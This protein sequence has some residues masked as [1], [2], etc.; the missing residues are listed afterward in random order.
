MMMTRSLP[1]RMLACP[2]GVCLGQAKSRTRASWKA[3]AA[4]FLSGALAVSAVVATAGMTTARTAAH[5]SAASRAAAAEFAALEREHSSR[6][7]PREWR[8]E[9]KTVDSDRMFRKQR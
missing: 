4:S 2:A 5:A 6:G 1:L 3:L 9:I 8:W 7:L